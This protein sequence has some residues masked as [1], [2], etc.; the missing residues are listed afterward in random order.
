M[1]KQFWTGKIRLE[2]QLTLCMV[3][4]QGICRTQCIDKVWLIQNYLQQEYPVSHDPQPEIKYRLIPS[5]S[6]N[7]PK[8]GSN[9]LFKGYDY[10][11]QFIL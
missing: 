2:L 4:K 9:N 8:E 5:N 6:T 1:E 11:G 7:L 10:F 3:P